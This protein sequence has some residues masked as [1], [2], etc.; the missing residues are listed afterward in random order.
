MVPRGKRLL[1]NSISLACMFMIIIHFHVL[2]ADLQTAVYGWDWVVN[3][4]L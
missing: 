3:C 2:T 4:W 1:R